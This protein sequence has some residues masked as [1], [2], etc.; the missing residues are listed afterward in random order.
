MILSKRITA[1]G[2]EVWRNWAEILEKEA[3]THGK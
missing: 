1:K 3:F 2:L